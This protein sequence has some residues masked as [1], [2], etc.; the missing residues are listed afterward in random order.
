MIDGNELGR[1]AKEIS[2]RVSWSPF[3]TA[4]ERPRAAAV[5][6][7]VALILFQLANGI[8]WI[9]IDRAFQGNDETDYLQNLIRHRYRLTHDDHKPSEIFERL[10]GYQR[11]TSTP[12]GL[13]H[14]WSL[15]FAIGGAAPETVRYVNLATLAAAMAALFFAARKLGGDTAGLLA[16]A[17]L[18]SFPPVVHFSHQAS[19]FMPHMMA[20][21]LVALVL[22]RSDFLLRPGFAI[23][24]G[25]AVAL[26]FQLERGTPVMIL[27]PMLAYLTGVVVYRMVR[28]TSRPWWRTGLPLVIAGAIALALTFAYLRG[29]L[30]FNLEHTMDMARE[31]LYTRPDDY[32][33]IDFRRLGTTPYLGALLLPLALFLL[34]RKNLGPFR[35]FLLV[36]YFG[37]LYLLSRVETRDVEYALGVLPLGALVIGVGLATIPKIP[38]VLPALALAGLVYFGAT[39]NTHLGFGSIDNP[40]WAPRLAAEWEL[41]PQRPHPVPDLRAAAEKV[42]EH[43][44]GGDVAIL[45]GFDDDPNY[46]YDPLYLNLSAA[47]MIQVYIACAVPDATHV[48]LLSDADN[49]VLHK[50]AG[51]FGV[52][53]MPRDRMADRVYGPSAASFNL[54]DAIG[55]L[56]HYNG[57][58]NELLAARLFEQGGPGPWEPVL[59]AQSRIVVSVPKAR[60]PNVRSAARNS[61]IENPKAENPRNSDL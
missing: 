2:R 26:D 17:A 33:K 9:G 60:G 47:N 45:Y 27:G 1:R 49:V 11:V 30:H 37:P 16:V 59:D 19:S 24:L 61:A 28:L 6:I 7:L 48:F 15:G 22:I 53:F 43:R 44:P 31:P 23:L 52:L 54:H 34:T 12:P 20:I 13:F 41:I 18:T 32:Y 29:F 39:L 14:L 55:G 8:A 21:A 40:G 35:G 38:R 42:L 51:N 25:L 46:H 56:W 58:D 57:P 36:A 4:E 3:G 10:L 50:P 5:A